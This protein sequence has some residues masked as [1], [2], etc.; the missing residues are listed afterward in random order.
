MSVPKGKR[1][2]EANPVLEKSRDLYAY[3]LKLMS[4]QQIMDKAYRPSLAKSI[5]SQAQA[6]CHCISAANAMA[7]F[8]KNARARKRL[9]LQLDSVDGIQM[10]I[11]DLYV[12]YR[13]GTIGQE[14]IVKAMQKVVDLDRSIKEWIKEDRMT[15]DKI[16]HCR[17]LDEVG[18]DDKFDE[19]VVIPETES[20]DL[21]QDPKNF[22]EIYELA[23]KSTH[24]KEGIVNN[25]S[26]PNSP[27]V[28]E[29]RE[30]QSHECDDATDKDIAQAVK[31][32]DTSKRRQERLTK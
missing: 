13:I 24:E 26:G 7:L 6:I 12:L 25:P 5:T 11:A 8:G 1:K 29:I 30:R 3:M 10:I 20:L 15:Y 32:L 2:E 9:L 27:V 17:N 23:L 21:N 28:D 18:F 16:L 14:R 4:D 19:S 31:L 22:Q